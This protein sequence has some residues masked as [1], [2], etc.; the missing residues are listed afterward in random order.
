[1]IGLEPCEKNILACFDGYLEDLRADD[2]SESSETGE[3]MMPRTADVEK[4][5]R[6]RG[7]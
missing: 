5:N 7:W 3:S 4:M 2:E 6:A 1:M